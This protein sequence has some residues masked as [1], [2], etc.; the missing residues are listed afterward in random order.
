MAVSPE[1]ARARDSVPLIDVG[2]L[3][4]PPCAARDATDG[5][6]LAAA[7]NIGFLSIVGLPAGVPT[8]SA[9]RAE[10]LRIFRLPPSELRKLWRRK[11]EP[12]NP[13]LYRGWFPVQPGN[14]TS[15][16][17]ID[18]GGDVAYGTTV[19]DPGD[20]LREATPLPSEATLSGWHAT[21]AAY[22]KAMD[23]VSA[24]LMRSIARGLGLDEQ[25]FDSAFHRGLSTLRLLHY[26]VRDAEEL[27]RCRSADLWVSHRGMRHYVAGAA[28]T[29]SGFMTLLAQDGVA[30]LQARTR[31][32]SWADVP[33]HE[34]ALAVNFGQVLERW[35]GGRIKATEHRV[36]GMG[37]ERFSI[38]FFYEACAHA[39]IHPLPLDDPKSFE[40]FL[41]GDFL[42]ARIVNF[43]EFRGMEA[44]RKPRRS[45]V[46][47]ERN[48]E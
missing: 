24:A 13:N 41:Y 31:D 39:E 17:G 47:P 28:H 16:E 2:A 45:A 43:V 9:A 32:G 25:Y 3:F 35:S 37:E 4:G 46:N 20:P 40:P 6:I 30:G 38:P 42:W 36:L 12:R 21:I 5:Q 22:Y 19:T 33:P 7:G 8:G 44:L 34:H 48:L 23:R 18:M 14:L 27:A 15:K 1:D 10:L 29:D 11:F 26:P